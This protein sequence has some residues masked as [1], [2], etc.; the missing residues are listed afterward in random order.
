MGSA[1]HAHNRH[2]RRDPADIAQVVE[3]QPQMSVNLRHSGKILGSPEGINLNSRGWSDGTP[4][5]ERNPWLAKEQTPTPKGCVSRMNVLLSR[6]I[7]G[8]V[9]VVS[10]DLILPVRVRTCAE[11]VGKTLEAIRLRGS[12][13]SA[14][15]QWDVAKRPASVAPRGS[16]LA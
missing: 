1:S 9:C 7:N 11:N 6:N 13:A 4:V 5:P 16:V 2:A 14:F 8:A 15:Q 10:T 3:G 12:V